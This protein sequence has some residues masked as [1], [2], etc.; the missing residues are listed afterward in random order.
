MSRMFPV[1][2]S[3]GSGT[4][5]WPLSRA[6][7]P[8][9]FIRFSE[10]QGVSFL[11][12]SLLRLPPRGGFERPI[13][14][15]N[16]AHRFLVRD[17]AERAGVEPGAIVLEPEARNTAP[18]IAVAAL[19]VARTAPDGVIVVMPSDHAIKD[20]AGFLA[21]V[22]GAGEVA[23]TGKLVLFGITPGSPH[24]G[25]GYIQRGEALPGFEGAFRVAAFAEKPCRE[26][27]QRYVA[28]REYYW[29]SGIFV[30]G[31]RAFLDEL[32]R[33]QPAVLAAADA[34]LQEARNEEGFLRLDAE[35]FAKAPIISVDYAVMEKTALAAVL[36]IDLG[37]SDVGS[38]SSLWELSTR[39]EQGNAVEGEAMLEATRDSYIHSEGAL[40]ATVGVKDLVIVSTPDALLVAD[41]GRAQ[42]VG[43][44]VARLRK[45]KR[46]E[47]VSHVRAHHQWGF[48][49][50][51]SVAAGFR[52]DLLHVSR[53]ATLERSLRQQHFGHWV[54]MQGS[55]EVTIGNEVKQVQAS[56][57]ISLAPGQLH[58]AY[59]PGDTPLVLIEVLLG[60][61]IGEDDMAA[62]TT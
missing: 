2:L 19:L 53:G 56:Q 29:N 35:A 39:D 25:Y 26:T 40:V 27:A 33:L 28:S 5:L 43:T 23:Q 16:N 50:K 47:A 37:W 15:C 31:V 10:E 21:A 30:L 18:A 44:I 57:S 55:A 14:V 48:S 41:R 22:R 13:I 1:I 36:P 11:A 42:D 38:W 20:E 3:G 61:G 34:A 12:A 46:R 6:A 49:Q 8:K 45:E 4:R 7:F 60:D 54:V 51:L 17:E 62:A 52:V 58:R 59:N 24:T 9:Q 32:E